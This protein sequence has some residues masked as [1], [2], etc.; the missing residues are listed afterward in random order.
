VEG[1]GCGQWLQSGGAQY[2][3]GLLHGGPEQTATIARSDVL[4]QPAL[5]VRVERALELEI[6]QVRIFGPAEH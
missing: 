3:V 4:L 5:L 2:I 1:G 6:H